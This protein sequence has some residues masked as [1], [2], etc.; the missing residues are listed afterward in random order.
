MT[1]ENVTKASGEINTLTIEYPQ[2][3]L[4]ALQLWSLCGRLT[5][6]TYW[7]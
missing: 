4:W 3:L 1:T 7:V 5:G 6:L 2:E